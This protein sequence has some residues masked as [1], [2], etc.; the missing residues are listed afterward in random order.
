MSLSGSQNM[1][2]ATLSRSYS[3]ESDVRLEDYIDDKLQSTTDLENLNSLLASIEVQRSQLQTQL[4]DAAQELA[5]VRQSAHDRQGGLARQIEEFEKLQ[6]S[7]DTRLQIVAASDA[8]D[9]AIQRLEAPMKQLH[10]VELAQD[11]IRLLQDVE[12][13]RTEAR[14]HLPQSPKAALE[15]Y[16]RLKRLSVRLRELQRAADQ[17]AG[18]LVAYVENVTSNL[19][20]EMKA[21]MSEEFSAVLKKRNWPQGVDPASEM[22]Q[23]WIQA[24][25]KL[26]DLQ[27]PEVLYSDTVVPLLPIDVMSTPFIQ[28]FKFQFMG[29]NPTSTP[30]AFGT[31]CA[32]NFISLIEKWEDFFRDNVGHVLASRFQNTAVADKAVYIDPACA[33]ITSLLPIMRQKVEDVVQHGLRNPQFLS[34]LMV[35]L[36][37]LDDNIRS[38]FNYDGGDPENG[39]PGLT[40]EVLDRHFR[41]WFKAEKDF[42]LERFQTILNSSDARNID[43][44][45]S[46]PGKMKPTYAAVRVTDLLKSV[47]SQYGRVRRLSHKIRFLID[48]QQEILDQY[49]ARLQ[50][51]LEAYSISTSTM[52]RTLQGVSKEQLAALEGTGKF[53][54]L[55]RVIGSSDHVVNTLKDWGNEEVFWCSPGLPGG[56]PQLT[57]NIV[58][59]IALGGAARQGQAVGQRIQPR[60]RDELRPCARPYFYSNRFGWG[61]N[62]IR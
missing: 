18:H 5:D 21:T 7:I 62:H 52:G 44:D 60:W 24:F 22:D 51:S 2:T 37:N 34:S 27:V 17:A 61:W 15:P 9:E 12:N 28:W 55:C 39:W 29:S 6:E 26:I 48:I 33:L 20:D 23:E 8:P 10:K 3:A 42:A 47:T 45:Y 32:P 30:Q 35:N 14:S 25:E 46:P 4:E 43:Y 40:S 19:W 36:M 57:M 31:F 13:Y 54:I 1:T 38:R 50:D 59:R 11:Y 58:L 56:M 53:D 16:S 49:H 41:T